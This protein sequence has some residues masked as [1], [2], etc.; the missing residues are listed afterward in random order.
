[1]ATPSQTDCAAVW[2]AWVEAGRGDAERYARYREVPVHLQPAVASHMKI[3]K[4]IE[5]FQLAR[6]ERRGGGRVAALSHRRVDRDNPY[7]G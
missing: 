1:V 6:S 7:G 2:Q 4:A 3:V 5:A